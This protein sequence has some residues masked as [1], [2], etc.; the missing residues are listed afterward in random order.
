MPRGVYD[1]SKPKAEKLSAPAAPAAKKSPII[2]AATAKAITKV[3]AAPKAAAAKSIKAGQATAQPEE[4]VSYGSPVAFGFQTL[5]NN[6][7]TLANVHSTLAS[8][9]SPATRTAIETEIHETLKLVSALRVKTFGLVSAE[10]AEV[11]ETKSAL[12]ETIQDVVEDLAQEEN[13]ALPVG[14]LPPAN[15]HFTP[16]A[17]PSLPQH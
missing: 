5:G 15:A 6:L 14:T 2:K 10:S 4:H 7:V 9:V 12:P 11:I 8:H 16:P 13:T 17:P 1:R 3:K